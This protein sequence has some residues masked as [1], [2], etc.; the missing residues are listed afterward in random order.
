MKLRVLQILKRRHK[1]LDECHPKNYILDH[2]EK[3]MVVNVFDIYFHFLYLLTIVKHYVELFLLFTIGMLK[4]KN[5]AACKQCGVGILQEERRLCHEEGCGVALLQWKSKPAPS[6]PIQK[7]C[8][9][10]WAM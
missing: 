2:N 4:H 5:V 6:C 10:K 7:A 1:S 9:V 8:T 3:L